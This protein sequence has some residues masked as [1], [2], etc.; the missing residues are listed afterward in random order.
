METQQRLV[1]SVQTLDIETG[2]HRRVINEMKFLRGDADAVQPDHLYP[3]TMLAV[4]TLESK[5]K[6]ELSMLLNHTEM[7]IDLLPPRSQT[8]KMRRLITRM[9]CKLE[10][11]IQRG[12]IDRNQ[13]YPVRAYLALYDEKGADEIC[14]DPECLFDD[15]FADLAKEFRKTKGVSDGLKSKK[16][17][18]YIAIACND[19]ETLHYQVGNVECYDP[20]A[21]D[22]N[23]GTDES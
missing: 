10:A 11:S 8:Y 2:D 20:Q 1:D 18:G 16:N 19:G 14:D 23:T 12:L 17:Q 22:D 9:A 13:K 4:G 7:W 6:Q 3:L 5:F 21:V 15:W